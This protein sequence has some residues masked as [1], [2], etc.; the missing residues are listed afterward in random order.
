MGNQLATLLPLEA[1]EQPELVMDPAM[2]TFQHPR[3]PMV[4]GATLFFLQEKLPGKTEA[5][6]HAHVGKF[7]AALREDLDAYYAAERGDYAPCL[8][9]YGGGVAKEARGAAQGA[10]DLIRATLIR[11]CEQPPPHIV[12][13]EHAKT[14]APPE[15][16]AQ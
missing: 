7:F 8:P 12:M 2:M 3:Q 6:K 4:P 10:L 15:V 16:K 5:E 11:T 9:A 14:F 13:E 1:A